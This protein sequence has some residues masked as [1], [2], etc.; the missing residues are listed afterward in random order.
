MPNYTN[1]MEYLESIGVLKQGNEEEI[2]RAK[3][4]YRKQYFREHKRKMRKN[5]LEVTM[6]LNKANG[7][8]DLIKSEAERHGMS[9]PTFIREATIAE[10][11]NTYI[12]P[13]KDRETLVRFKLFFSKLLSVMKPIY[14]GDDER[15]RVMEK[16]IEAMQDRVIQAIEHPPTLQEAVKQAIQEDPSL[17]PKLLNFISAKGGQVT[18]DRQS[19]SI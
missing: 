9:I 12:V 2:K 18:H 17:A 15:Y 7:D 13:A 4:E 16:R 11:H 6:H 14:K 1:M 3:K 5:R 8:Y 10:L 19:K